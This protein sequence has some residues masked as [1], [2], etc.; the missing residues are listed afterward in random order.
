MKIST[1]LTVDV[2]GQLTEG[3]AHQPGLNSHKRV[4]DLALS[5]ALA[6]LV[7]TESMTT[8]STALDRTSIL[9]I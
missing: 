9:A 8:I 2:A 5:S 4:A 3:L 6:L 1:H 7:S